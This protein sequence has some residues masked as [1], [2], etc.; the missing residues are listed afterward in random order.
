MNENPHKE[1]ETL[2]EQLPL[3]STAR[4]EHQLELRT[5]L[6]E[7]F[8]DTSKWQPEKRGLQ[9]IGR[10]LMQYKA[11]HWLAAA[12]LITCTVWFLQLSSSP[13]YAFKE[14]ASHVI[15]AHTA[16]YDMVCKVFG[17]PDI[18]M[19]AFYRE[20][21]H[22][23]QELVEGYVNI[24]DWGAGR[25]ILLDSKNKHATVYNLANLSDE[26]KAALQNTGNMFETIRGA[27]KN[28]T[29]A[30]ETKVESLGEKEI[31]GKKV[32]GFRL[33]GQTSPMTVWADPQTKFPVRIETVNLG[34]PKT[35]V[36]MTN[37]EFDVEL[38][39]SLFSVDI[40]DGY[41]VT[42]VDMDSSP[43]SEDELLDTLRL[44]SEADDGNLPTNIDQDAISTSIVKY[45]KHLGVEDG[46]PSSEQL[47]KVMVATRGFQFAM[48]L[49]AQADAHYA[50]GAKLGDKDRPVFWYKP[51][52][53]TTYRVIFADMTIGDAN[54]PPTIDGAS[55]LKN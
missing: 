30:T 51:V 40:P 24:A 8:D 19:K 5:R 28:A 38:D 49:P 31:D 1:W 22:L 27:I 34:P 26:K 13:A 33:A 50:G 2:F 6:L 10:T 53:S 9:R 41:T 47:E 52:D 15:K 44:L 48:A 21:C 23:R 18:T 32:I 55:K 39:E 17:Q 20:P 36:V 43:P 14:V 42:E 4:T 16:R 12:T 29:D 37:Y 3:E 25:M 7:A 54:T 46:K 11:P 45:M 35:E